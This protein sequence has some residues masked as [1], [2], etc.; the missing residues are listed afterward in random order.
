MTTEVTDTQAQEEAP[1][2]SAPA[3]DKPD[4]FQRIWHGD[5]REKLLKVPAGTVDCIITDP[6]FGVDNKSNMATTVK[7]KEYARK[8]ANDETPEKAI[9]VFK[10]VMNVLC[11]RTADDADM[12]VFTAHQVLKEWLHVADWLEEQHGFK[13]NAL[14]IWDKQGPGMG[15]LEGWG[16]GY[17]H[18]IFLKKGRKPRFARR[19]TGIISVPQ[20]RPSELIHPHEK[21]AALLQILMKHSMRERDFAVD[22]FGGSGSLPRAAGAIGRS[23][24][25]IEY[26]KFNY[27]RAKQALNASAGGMF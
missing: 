3:V 15:D 4:P 20:L 5:S 10:E 9:A 26:D 7:G 18:I 27:D 8:I 25:A 24:L 16:M 22:P 11:P 1:A 23:A 21:P 6:P 19:R 2:S 17:E 13:K 14:L 12:Y